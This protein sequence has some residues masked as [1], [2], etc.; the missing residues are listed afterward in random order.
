M[1]ANF[2][3]LTKADIDAWPPRNYVDPVDRQ[4]M[5]AFAIVWQVISTV[6]AAGRFYLRARG[7]AGAFGVD[8]LLIA[9]AWVRVAVSRDFALKANLL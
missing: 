8:D 1:P 6:L 9:I 4:W 5:P 3:T 2:Y 7:M